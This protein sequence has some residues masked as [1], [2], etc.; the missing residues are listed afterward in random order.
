MSEVKYI[1]KCLRLIEQ[2]FNRGNSK[3]WTSENYKRLQKLILEASGITLST[4]TLERLY[5]KLKTHNEYNPQAETKNALA[6]FLGYADWD[7][8]KIEN[9]I[10]VDEIEDA[11]KQQLSSEI[12]LSPEA[13]PKRKKFIYFIAIGIAIGTTAGL[14]LLNRKSRSIGSNTIIQFRA[15]NSFGTVPHSVK[16]LY[17]LS[18][19]EGNNFSIFFP[20][21]GDT[22]QIVKTQTFTYKPFIWPGH[23][24][25]Y[26]LSDKKTLAQADVYIQTQGWEGYY[27]VRH[28]DD[29]SRKTA[30]PANL[31]R[32]AGRLYTPYSFFPDSIK[33]ADRYFI[34][35]V[36][37]RDYKVDGDNASFETRFR[38]TSLERN[39]IC[40][41]MWFIL[42]GTKGI[43]KM[44]FLMSGCFAYVDMT[45]GDNNMKG[46]KQDLSPFSIDIH[47]WKKARLEVVDKNVRIYLEN[48]L[49]YETKYSMSVGKIVGIEVLSKTSGET[50][51]VKLYNAKKE[52]VY[53][54][55]F[56]GK[57]SD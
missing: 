34:S 17:D 54:D 16:F 37:I 45:L 53:E 33:K 11:L 22:V 12:S 15:V 20:K 51:Y 18:K 24:V 40:N 3:D 2:K 26:L 7:T 38:N 43:L 41:D 42:M 48:S 5:G 30:I 44:H 8:F 36:N 6:I 50:D 1:S 57:P 32:S 19:L 13:N 31:L 23:H 46:A 14:I 25:A 9:P 47:N 29:A 52:L 4:H 28:P 39:A 35:Y 27:F 49:I 10:S 56:G 21:N 55:D